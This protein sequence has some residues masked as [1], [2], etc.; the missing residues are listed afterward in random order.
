MTRRLSDAPN[1]MRFKAL[2]VAAA[3]ELAVVLVYA[4]LVDSPRA[5][6]VTGPLGLLVCVVAY[7][8]ALAIMIARDQPDHDR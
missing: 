4:A 7:T 1:Q 5:W 8:G 2:G 3:I 6:I